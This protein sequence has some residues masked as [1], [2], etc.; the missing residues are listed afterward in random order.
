MLSH[1]YPPVGGGGANACMNLS[2][3]FAAAG[4]EVHILTVCF[5]G[6]SSESDGSDGTIRLIRL[7]AV[8]RY[9][10]HSSFFEML[11]YL[12]K[13]RRISDKLIAEEH[14][15]VCLCFFGIPSGPLAFYLKRKYGLPYAIRFGG[16]DIPGFQSRFKPVY[17]L[18][19]PFIIRIWENADALIANSAGLKSLACNFCARYPIEVIHTGVD[20]DFFLPLPVCHTSD[21]IRLL[22][23]SRLVERKGLQDLIPWFHQIEQKSGKTVEWIIVGNGPY[24]SRLKALIRKYGLEQKIRLYSRREKSEL[25]PFYQNADVFIF[26]SHR[27]GLPNAVLEAMACGLP[28]IMYADCQG[29]S[30][31]VRGNGVQA[32]RGAFQDAVSELLGRS[33]QDRIRMGK[34]SRELAESEFSW[35]QCA[36][37]YLRILKHIC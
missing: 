28:V 29:S 1:E 5:D 27:E 12:L 16:G 14:Y 17:P 22:T 35:A 34:R 21:K 10:D 15:D 23:V 25:L 31:L 8:R 4:H 36:A 13:A 37:A 19:S 33:D 7:H 24:R 9:T 6:L 20:T 11:D 26:P 32:D 3:Q 2:K 30:E 18:L